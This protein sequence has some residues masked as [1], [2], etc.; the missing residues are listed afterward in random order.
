MK[1]LFMIPCLVLAGCAITSNRID[2]F[3][4]LINIQHL[5][6]DKSSPPTQTQ[7]EKLQDLYLS[8]FPE[9][10]TIVDVLGKSIR[11]SQTSLVRNGRLGESIED[12]TWG[13]VFEIPS[14]RTKFLYHNSGRVYN[15]HHNHQDL[16]SRWDVANLIE[17]AKLATGNS[18]NKDLLIGWIQKLEAHENNF[19]AA[20]KVLGNISLR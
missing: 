9:Q 3:N 11:L 15:Q 16:I 8:D 6:Y 7:M 10:L 17:L 4:D 18:E 14:A 12:A 20:G 1:N 13:I 2:P 5:N 19:A